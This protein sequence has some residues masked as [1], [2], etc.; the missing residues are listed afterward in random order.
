MFLRING[1][2]EIFEQ[3]K[4]NRL[5][6]NVSTGSKL[7]AMSG[8]L[9]VMLFN[10]IPREVVPFYA[11][12]RGTGRGKSETEYSETWGVKEIEEV[13][14]LDLPKPENGQLE[15]LR[16]IAENDGKIKKQAMINELCKR[17]HMT[18]YVLVDGVGVVK[19]G[20]EAEFTATALK[21][22]KRKMK[23]QLRNFISGAIHVAD[24]GII[25]ALKVRWKAV[26]EEDR[27][28]NRHMTLTKNGKILCKIFFGKNKE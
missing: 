26:E 23:P 16:I 19:E 9:A 8:I 7:D 21:T 20:K 14:T 11:H 27:P 4:E 17:G 25:R 28:K 2:R 10:K 12:P 1:L 15:A 18:G 3:E 5:F 13:P 24:N 6:L 22:K